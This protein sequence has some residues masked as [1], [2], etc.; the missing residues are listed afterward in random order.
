[1]DKFGIFNLINS[2]FSL[3]NSKGE[4]T[5]DDQ[6]PNM[7]NFSQNNSANSNSILD[8]FKNLTTQKPQE[9]TQK[10]DAVQKEKTLKHTQA[11]LNQM[12]IHEEFVKRVKNTNK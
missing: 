6:N 11:L 10:Q 3:N 2:L 7:E 4:S 1:M 5:K 8:L 12:K 9:N